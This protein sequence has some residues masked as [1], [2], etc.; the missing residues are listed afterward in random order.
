MRDAQTGQGLPA[1]GVG[2]ARAQL[3]QA[4][5][6]APGDRLL[7][8]GQRLEHGVRPGRQ[9]AGQ[10]ARPAGPPALV[11]GERQQPPVH[12]RP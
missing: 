4:Q 1:R 7:I 6:D 9:D 11:G 2:P 12:A 3:H 10:A 8:G 5:Q